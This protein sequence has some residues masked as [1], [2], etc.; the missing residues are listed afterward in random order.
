MNC[1]IKGILKQLISIQTISKQSNLEMINYLQ[2]ELLKVNGD[3][4]INHNDKND[5]ANLICFF[6]P[7]NE[8]GGVVISAHTDTVPVDET[9]WTKSPFDLTEKIDLNDNLNYYGRGCADMKGFIAQ[10]LY[11]IKRI[12]ISKL[13]KPLVYLLTYDEEVGCLGVHSA[14]DYVKT[15]S[16]KF[17]TSVLIGEPTEFKVCIAHKGHTQMSI[18][19]TGARGHSSQIDKGANSII[20]AKEVIN[21]IEKIAKD[22]RNDRKFEDI[23]GDYPFRSINI[24]TI[25]G[26][27][28]INIIPGNCEL[29]IG[30]RTLP[31]DSTD[32]IFKTIKQRIEKNVFP[33]VKKMHSNVNIV[34]KMS[35][36]VPPMMTREGS[37][38]EK[39]CREITGHKE[40]MAAS[41]T[42]EGGVMSDYNM[43]CIILGPGSISNAHKAD[44]YISK[45]DLESGI[46]M[47]SEIIQQMCL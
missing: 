24:G 19:I 8:E 41:Y 2:R 6:G 28:A 23:F 20:I 46:T 32:Y 43:D 27:S 31:G 16:R 36:K 5:K 33:V 21:E 44:E 13:N 3:I 18:E 4:Y 47:L 26:G 22:L 39:V 25:S 40:R 30:Y 12:D 11:V 17:P 7:Q 15:L 10:M 38:L 9:K 34:F 35:N 42:T 45:K 14:L 1:E 37:E 29:G